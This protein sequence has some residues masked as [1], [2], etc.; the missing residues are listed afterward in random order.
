[1]TSYAGML[2]D[3]DG[4]LV[5]TAPDMIGTVNDL[6]VEHGL[7]TL[8]A[9][10]L[11][12]HVSHGAVAMIR[13]SFDLTDEHPGFELLRQTFLSHYASRLADESRPFPGILDVLN[14]LEQQQRPWGVVTNKPSYLTDPLLEQLGLSDRAAVV[15]SGD[16]LA[17]AKPDPLPLTTACQRIQLAPADVLYIGDAERDIQAAKAAGNPSCLARFGYLG[18]DDRPDEWD[19]DRAINRADELLAWI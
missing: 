6:R 15:I 13:A 18:A 10:V 9:D 3:L 4:T 1:M 16:T 19:A 8:P 17:R 12:P 11:R 5:D 7:A 2:F 14:S